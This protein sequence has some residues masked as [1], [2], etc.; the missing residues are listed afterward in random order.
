MP[1]IYTRGI[2]YGGF[3]PLLV[4]EKIASK[5]ELNTDFC[6][7]VNGE[8]TPPPSVVYLRDRKTEYN[9]STPQ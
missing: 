8:A 6:D 4:T 1:V 2:A 3:N 7:V 5:L 9:V